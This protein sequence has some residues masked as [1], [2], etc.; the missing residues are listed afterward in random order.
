MPIIFEFIAS[1][2]HPNRVA[3]FEAVSKSLNTVFHNSQTWSSSGV[4]S[5]QIKHAFIYVRCD[6]SVLGLLS[7]QSSVWQDCYNRALRSEDCSIWYQN[8]APSLQEVLVVAQKYGYNDIMPNFRSRLHTRLGTSH[9]P[10]AFS[11][12]CGFDAIAA[13]DAAHHAS[14]IV[15]CRTFCL[16]LQG[17]L[18]LFA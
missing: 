3:A 14:C 12:R 4:L 17:C 18:P 1:H 5:I 10:T 2:L 6:L 13:S 8:G 7:W 9:F 15:A 16:R 11:E